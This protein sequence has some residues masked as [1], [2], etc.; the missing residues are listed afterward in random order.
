MEEMLEKFPDE[1][2]KSGNFLRLFIVGICGKIPAKQIRRILREAFAV[3]SI[4]PCIG[5]GRIHIETIKVIQNI[6]HGK[7]A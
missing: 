2:L 6:T 3:S 1:F 4:A 5:L 7:I